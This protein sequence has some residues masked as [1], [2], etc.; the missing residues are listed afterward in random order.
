MGWDG[1]V[2]ARDGDCRKSS[3]DGW[4]GTLEALGGSG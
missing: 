3:L 1:K 2:L 4:V